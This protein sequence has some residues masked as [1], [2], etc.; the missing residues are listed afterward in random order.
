MKGRFVEGLPP[1]GMNIRAIFDVAVVRLASSHGSLCAFGPADIES[2]KRAEVQVQPQ[3]HDEKH[4]W[5]FSF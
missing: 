3:S 5:L 2:R 1:K 4:V